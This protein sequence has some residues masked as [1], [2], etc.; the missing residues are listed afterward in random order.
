MTRRQVRAAMRRMREHAEEA[1]EETGELNLVPYMDI[2]TNIIIFLLA[3]VV[4]SIALG[5]VNVSLPTIGSGGGAAQEEPEKPPLNLTIT[6]GAKGF[7]IA[8]SGG[9]MPII[10]KKG[11]I[12]DYK[13]LTTKLMEIKKE[14]PDET[15]ATFNADA[16]TE[17]RIV[18]E[19]LD[20]MR[21]DTNHNLMFPDVVF[22]AGIL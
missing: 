18:V 9:V 5:N 11:E 1:E 20:A 22:S 13:G 2:V 14:F 3:S 8:A 17:Y 12:Y 19:T 7:I 16:G 15:K 21:E 6:A 4:N 10:P